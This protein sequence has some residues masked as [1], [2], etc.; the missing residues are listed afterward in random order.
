MTA[1]HTDLSEPDRV[2]VTDDETGARWV[3]RV[4]TNRDGRRGLDGPHGAADGEACAPDHIGQAT[5]LAHAE[6]LHAGL[7]DY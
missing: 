5:V 4:T 2:S 1:M 6:A 3:F 7:V